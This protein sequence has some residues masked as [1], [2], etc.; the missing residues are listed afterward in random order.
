[1]NAYGGGVE[2]N[3]TLTGIVPGK[4][5]HSTTQKPSAFACMPT[6]GAGQPN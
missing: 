3:L 2:S 6:L 1:M 5:Q 4:Q